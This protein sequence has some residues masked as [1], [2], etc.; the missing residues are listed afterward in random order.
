MPVRLE[1]R[2]VGVEEAR[3]FI[4]S[5]DRGMEEEVPRKFLRKATNLLRNILWFF[6]PVRTGKMRDSISLRRGRYIRVLTIDS[7]Y[8]IYVNEGVF[9]HRIPK[10]GRKLMHFV[11]PSGEEVFT[12]KVDH[13]GFE[14]RHFVERA[15]EVFVEEMWQEFQMEID[16]E[17]QVLE[18]SRTPL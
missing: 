4:D 2:K 5:L 18:S 17:I 7:P 15:V 9:P 14:G 11:K 8:A 12:Y 1:V 13:P 3:A 10:T 6:M 16:A